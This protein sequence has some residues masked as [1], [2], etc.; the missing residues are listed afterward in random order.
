MNVANYTIINLTLI[1][2]WKPT[3]WNSKLSNNIYKVYNFIVVTVTLSF[4]LYLLIFILRFSKDVNSLTESI[5][6]F[7]GMLGGFLKMLNFM[8]NREEIITVD[9]MLSEEICLPRDEKEY[10]ILKASKN[11]G[12]SLS[13]LHQCSVK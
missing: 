6:I 10:F 8:A 1:G 13:Y 3:S 2:A 11:N 4:I 12:R 9:R 7:Y 5:L